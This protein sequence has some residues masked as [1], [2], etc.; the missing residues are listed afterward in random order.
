MS[1]TH[2]GRSGI[3]PLTVTAL[4][5]VYGDIGTSPLYAIRE[6]FFGTH[7][8]P[9][10]PENVLGVLSLIIYALVLV[11]S[12]KYV[13]IVMRADNQGEGGILALTSLIPGR[14]GGPGAISRL[15]VGRPVLVALGIFG[16]ALLYG[17]GMITPAISV[18]G[19]VEGL[20]V[21]TPLFNPYVVPVTVVILLALFIIQQ[22]GTHRVGGLF[23]P[24]VIIWFLVI[25][26][27]GV[28]WILRAPAVLG[29]FDPRH[30]LRF[31]LENGVPGFA[32]LGAVFLVVTGGEALYAD[33]GH[34]GKYP[35]RLAWFGLVLPAL[36][37][38]YLGQGALLLLRPASSQPFFM[39]APTW[40][41][42]PLVGLATAAAIIA[43]QA[44]ISGSFSVTRQAIQL[45]LAP[46]LDVAHTS[47]S[48]MGQIYVP[49]VNW[50]LMA[51][52]VSIV[53]GFGSS[54]A[55]AAA[56]G[57]AVTM[58]M[59]IDELLLFVVATERW[60]WPLAGVAAVTGTFL[61][62]DLAFFGAN[63]LKVMQGGWVTL[64]VATLIFTL[65]TTW[66][67]GRRLLGERLTARALPLEEFMKT[68]EAEPPQRVP[69]TAVFMTAQ[70]RGT[71][72]ALVHNVR[73][74][75]VL[76]EHVVV[77]MVTTAQVP[78]VPPAERVA[79]AE[80]LGNG[81]FN[82][83]L[84]FGFMDDPDVPEA[85]LLAREKGVALD[86]VD[87]TYF[88]GRETIL[89]TRKEGMAL[90]RERLFVLMARNAVRATAFFRLPPERVVEL[91]VQVEM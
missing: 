86:P 50:A 45:G 62:V 44:L 32:V 56:Y 46:R 8:V 30:A 59:V 36:V 77:L 76:H 66:R 75:K 10:T 35:I 5:V 71:P 16:T 25:G 26:G 18:L 64:V 41:L 90:W 87:L 12:V 84:Q 11:I 49:Q 28:L 67:T 52:T 63:V 91:G 61:T 58:T 72:P 47:A 83:R 69:G 9:P 53:I 85:L 39:L 38:N 40:A 48:A 57:I 73:Y 21:I 80:P 65:M 20:G 74:N 15:A 82:V 31:F 17:D 54:G 22:F 27:L 55:V 60:R 51:A 24:I 89:V 13:G 78:H 33:M 68:V 2:T 14:D 6:C 7:P 79:L 88:L 3:L 81:I 37:L 4:G 19:A 29:A 34:F 43:S 42:V 1:R 70:P 23:G